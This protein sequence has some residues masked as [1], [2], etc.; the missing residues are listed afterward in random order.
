VK[1]ILPWL[2]GL[3]PTIRIS[4]F[5][6]KDIADNSPENRRKLEKILKHYL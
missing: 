2:H 3:R 5:E 4:E 1:D 6:V